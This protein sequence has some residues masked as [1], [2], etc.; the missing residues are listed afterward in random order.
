MKVIAAKQSKPPLVIEFNEGDVRNLLHFYKSISFG[1]QAT[2]FP[3]SEAFV[4][5]L[6]K[7]LNS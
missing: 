1:A 2:N 5:M 4:E 7:Y 3:S 6:H